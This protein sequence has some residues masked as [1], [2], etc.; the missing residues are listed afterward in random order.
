[1]LSSWY[2]SY[3]QAFVQL[4][5]YFLILSSYK[6]MYYFSCIILTAAATIQLMFIVT[7]KLMREDIPAVLVVVIVVYH[8]ILVYYAYQANR[9]FRYHFD[10]QFGEEFHSISKFYQTFMES[11]M[12]EKFLKQ[13]QYGYQQGSE[14]AFKKDLFYNPY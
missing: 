4:L 6:S 12:F 2:I 11:Q 1:M 9:I 8:L 3:E 14:S 13:K 5:H 10:K 7:S